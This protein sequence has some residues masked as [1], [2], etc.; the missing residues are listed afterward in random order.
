[1]R[2]KQIWKQVMGSEDDSP[3]LTVSDVLARLDDYPD[4]C[5]PLTD[6]N[7]IGTFGNR[8]IHL[9][10]WQGN[11]EEIRVLVEGGAEVNVVGDMGA[12][13]LHEAAQAGHAEA[14]LFLLECG[15]R[16]DVRDEFG[17]TPLDWALLNG[18]VEVT[19]VLEGCK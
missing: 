6:V 1:L 3:R 16:L 11:V 5:D 14:A 10:S 18:H 8:P 2:N 9:V 12:T 13:P 7:Q 4:F 15:A 19:K 17:H